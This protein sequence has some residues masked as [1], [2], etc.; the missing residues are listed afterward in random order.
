MTLRA[1]VF[2]LFGTLVEGWSRDTADLK[3]DEL[4]AVLD[5]DASSFRELMHT[6][7][8][9]R[10]T[11]QLGPPREMLRRLAGMLQADPGPD[12]LERASELRVRQFHGVLRQPRAEVPSLL[13]VL[14]ARSVPV[15]M[16][17]DCSGETPAVWERLP[18]AR[19][20][21]APVFSWT[22]G[23]RKPAAELYLAA[24]ERLGVDPRE[25][26]YIGDGG[27]HELSGAEAAG[28]RA[29]QLRPEGGEAVSMLQYDPDLDWQG[30]VVASLS[31]LLP[32]LAG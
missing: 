8:T 16:I 6:T 18:W 27:S 31:A 24:S 22:E 1:V 11:G 10:A 15:G 32:L 14:R 5:L 30:E 23:R 3:L 29:L 19:P 7:Y 21:Q 17:T 13:A 4:A 2:D 20:I 28:M 25:C 9:L 26:V 12:R